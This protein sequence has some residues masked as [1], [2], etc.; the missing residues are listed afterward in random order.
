[1]KKTATILAYQPHG[2]ST[3]CSLVFYRGRVLMHFD[4]S[5]VTSWG[6]LQS[7]VRLAATEWA[8]GQGFTHFKHKKG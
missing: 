7:A 2:T 8:E 1:M 6:S 3:W 5:D 4:A